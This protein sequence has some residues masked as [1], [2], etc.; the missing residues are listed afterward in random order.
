MLAKVLPEIDKMT[1]KI[2]TKYENK[3]VV[4]LFQSMIRNGREIDK[5]AVPNNA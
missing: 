3:L 4:V 2:G 5:I 1:H